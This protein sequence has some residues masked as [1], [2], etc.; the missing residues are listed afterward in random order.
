MKIE[1]TKDF[2]KNAREEARAYAEKVNSSLNKRTERNKESPLKREN[3]LVRVTEETITNRNRKNVP[4]KA[5]IIRHFDPI[6]REDLVMVKNDASIAAQEIY[7]RLW[8]NVMQEL[9]NKRTMRLRGRRASQHMLSTSNS[10]ASVAHLERHLKALETLDKQ[11]RSKL[12]PAQ[13]GTSTLRVTKQ[14]AERIEMDFEE[15]FL[16]NS[17][18]STMEMNT[19]PLPRPFVVHGLISYP[20]SAAVM[21]TA[22]TFD[23]VDELSLRNSDMRTPNAVRSNHNRLINVSDFPAQQFIPWRSVPPLPNNTTSL[24]LSPSSPTTSEE[25]IS[26]GKL[27]D[28]SASAALSPQTRAEREGEGEV[29]RPTISSALPEIPAKMDSRPG[30]V[31]RA[32]DSIRTV[33]VPKVKTDTSFASAFSDEVRT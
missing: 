2:Q 4:V 23:R 16:S 19:D 7:R 11:R 22:T 3:F 14:S 24:L 32:T 30:S 20:D 28:V 21:E 25:E 29:D 15:Q 18:Q 26:I 27:S 31:S 12:S 17:R 10:P 8:G 13:G 9:L 5:T 1:V 33:N 6:P